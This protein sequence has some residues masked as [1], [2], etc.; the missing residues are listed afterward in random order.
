MEKTK[1]RR[2]VEVDWW[3]SG[4]MECGWKGCGFMEELEKSRKSCP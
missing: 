2:S 3:R 1:E 4:E